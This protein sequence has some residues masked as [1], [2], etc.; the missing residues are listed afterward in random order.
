MNLM[1]LNENISNSV[2]NLSLLTFNLSD[3]EPKNKNNFNFTNL[4]QYHF[5]KF[6]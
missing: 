4:H 5:D 2:N 3:F 1:S 6:K